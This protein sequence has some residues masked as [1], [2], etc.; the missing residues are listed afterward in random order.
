[1]S[2]RG[3]TGISIA[4]ITGHDPN[5]PAEIA[6]AEDAAAFADLITEL[7]AHRKE[8]GLTQKQVAASME[9]TQSA[10]SD[11]ERIGGNPTL[12]TMQSYA[13]AVGLRL[14][15]S[16]AP[17]DCPVPA[18]TPSRTIASAATASHQAPM[19]DRRRPAP[20]RDKRELVAA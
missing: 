10:V 17:T 15:F 3:N 20:A 6:A 5:D 12:S 19:K 14:Q 16:T 2:S 8:R 11:F 7:V 13:R 1:M 9:T 18:D 4:A